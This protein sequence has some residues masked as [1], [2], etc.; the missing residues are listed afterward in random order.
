[1]GFEFRCATCDQVHHGVPTFGFDAPAIAQ[2]IPENEKTVSRWEQMTVSSIKSGSCSWVP[3]FRSMV[4]QS[5]CLGRRDVSRATLNDGRTRSIL[6]RAMTSVHSRAPL[7]PSCRAIQTFNH[8]V[9]LY[10]RN[11]G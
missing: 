11:H 2:R 8:S 1:M 7:V 5:I 4:E 10:L 9:P 3:L 6:R